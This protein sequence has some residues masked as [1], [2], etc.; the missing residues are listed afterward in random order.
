MSQG[1]IT[2][3]LIS[4]IATAIAVRALKAAIVTMLL[5]TEIDE[6]RPDF[7]AKAAEG[8]EIVGSIYERL[9]P[10]MPLAYPF[11]NGSSVTAV[12]DLYEEEIEIRF[13][14]VWK[15]ELF[16]QFQRKD[17]L[18]CSD[19]NGL[20]ITFRMDNDRIYIDRNELPFEEQFPLILRAGREWH[21]VV[22]KGSKGMVLGNAVP[23]RRDKPGWLKV[24]WDEGVQYNVSPSI[25]KPNGFVERLRD[26]CFCSSSARE[27][28]RSRLSE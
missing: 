11:K 3:L 1:V 2:G 12:N 21:V 24:Q 17:L 5:V 27:L 8:D 23:P 14:P 28:S 25:V 4:Y 10:H 13:S 26:C 15:D 22:S 16:R 18:K 7:Y 6:W 20:E 9:W 19:R